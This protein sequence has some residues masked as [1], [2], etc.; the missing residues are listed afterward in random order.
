MTPRTYWV[1]ILGNSYGILYTGMTNDLMR[2][3]YEHKNHSIEGF[4]KTYRI[5]RL[6]YFEETD[7]VSTAI[8]K[9]KEIKGWL[10]QKKL[11]LIRTNNPKFE[12][13]SKDW[14]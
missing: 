13:L 4:T 8:Q 1:Y 7:N 9:E 2:R 11:D 3:M 5:D 14:F 10:R 6:L 12:D